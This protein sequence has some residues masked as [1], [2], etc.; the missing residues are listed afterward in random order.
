[1][2]SLGHGERDLAV[3]GTLKDALRC[4]LAQAG[5]GRVTARASSP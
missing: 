1:M 2:A 4:A 3:F 5:G